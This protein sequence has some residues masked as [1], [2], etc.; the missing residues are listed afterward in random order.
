VHLEDDL[1]NYFGI[2]PYVFTN[3]NPIRNV[4]ANGNTPAEV[5]YFIQPHRWAEFPIASSVA[6]EARSMTVE[7]IRNTRGTN[8]DF[9][10]SQ[11]GTYEDND[12]DAFRHAFL[13]IRLRQELGDDA[14]KNILTNHEKDLFNEQGA[15]KE[16]HDFDMFN[17]EVALNVPLDKTVENSKEYA[18]QLAVNLLNQGKLQTTLISDT[19]KSK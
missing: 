2:N 4:D 16:Q 10:I 15:T 18:K 11:K 17:N 1:K 19:V 5:V 7:Y 12:V 8:A 9:A 3:N 14:A 13:T 6:D